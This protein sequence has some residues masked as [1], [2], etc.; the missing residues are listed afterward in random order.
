MIILTHSSDYIFRIIHPDS[1]K[2]TS[3]YGI[4]ECRVAKKEHKY[5][6]TTDI[7]TFATKKGNYKSLYATNGFRDTFAKVFLYQNN[8]CIFPNHPCNLLILFSEFY[9]IHIC[10]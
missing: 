1:I 2:I 7:Y 3:A 6:Q 8:S 5:I 10:F 4:K 9:N